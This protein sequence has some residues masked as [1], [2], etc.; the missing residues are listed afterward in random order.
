[1]LI[2]RTLLTRGREKNPK[3]ATLDGQSKHRSSPFGHTIESDFYPSPLKSSR[4]SLH[5]FG[6]TWQLRPGEAGPPPPPTLLI[7][8]SPNFR[9]T[10][11]GDEFPL[12]VAKSP[13]SGDCSPGFA[14][15][16]IQRW[17]V[18][19]ELSVSRF[20]TA[21]QQKELSILFKISRPTSDTKTFFRL[22][23]FN[24]A[25]LASASQGLI[26]PIRAPLFTCISCSHFHWGFP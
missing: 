23:Y 1:M 21:C 15:L 13:L 16:P 20:A 10:S 2:G 19:L 24:L 12:E 9:W 5:F 4:S 6:P 11:D 3:G 22:F 7:T 25:L 26:T 17:I 8:Y 18:T 14:C